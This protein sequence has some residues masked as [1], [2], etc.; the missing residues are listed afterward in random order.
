MTDFLLSPMFWQAM[1][2]TVAS[3]VFISP[4]FYN[5]DYS[6]PIRAAIVLAICSFFSLFCLSATRLEDLIVTVTVIIL[7][8]LMFMVG[9]YLGVYIYNQNHKKITEPRKEFKKEGEFVAGELQ[10]KDCKTHEK[11]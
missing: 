10:C 9:L 6:K 3:G 11:F 4:V 1:G 2:F 5:G 8:N 7:T